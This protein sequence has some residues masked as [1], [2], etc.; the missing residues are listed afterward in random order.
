MSKEQENVPAWTLD[1]QPGFLGFCE[2]YHLTSLMLDPVGGPLRYI[3]VHMR[4]QK[5]VKRGLFFIQDA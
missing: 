5:H 4:V 2:G 3:G 1:P